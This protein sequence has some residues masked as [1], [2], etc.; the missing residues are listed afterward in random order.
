[1]LPD[2]WEL[3]WSYEGEGSFIVLVHNE[4]Y[5][6]LAAN[7]ID[8][9]EGTYYEPKGGEYYFDVTASGDWDII[10]VNVEYNNKTSYCIDNKNLRLIV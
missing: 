3:R 9:G 5:P 4:N 10:I 7:H 2:G 1:M 6:D 8:S